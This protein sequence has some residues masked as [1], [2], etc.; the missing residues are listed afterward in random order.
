MDYHSILYKSIRHFAVESAG[1][2]DFDAE[3]KIW[4][5]GMGLEPIVKTFGKDADVYRVQAL[6]AGCVAKQ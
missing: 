2:F 6:L 5:A 4:A 3:L 1:S